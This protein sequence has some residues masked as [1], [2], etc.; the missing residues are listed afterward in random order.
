MGGHQ[1]GVGRGEVCRRSR[2]PRE[3][4]AA[5]P[6][7]PSRCP[8]IPPSPRPVREAEA[9]PLSSVMARPGV[10]FQL[11]KPGSERA[12]DLLKSHSRQACAPGSPVLDPLE[13][14]ASPAPDGKNV[15]PGGK[16][17]KFLSRFQQLLTCS[18]RFPWADELSDPLF[19]GL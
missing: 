12:S 4:A 2:G 19:R 18:R 11:G 3:S 15:E 14:P 16:C 7:I 17:P 1:W 9:P 13:V 8:L 10:L 6:P 5:V